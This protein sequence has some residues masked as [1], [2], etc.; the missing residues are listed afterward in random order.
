MLVTGCSAFRSLKPSEP[1]SID[2]AV[3]T[4]SWIFKAQNAN[5]QS[6]LFRQLT[7]PYSVNLSTDAL[8]S[9]LPYFGEAYSGADVMT[10]RSPLDFKS[11]NLAVVKEKDKKGAWIITVKPKDYEAVYAYTFTVYD[12]GRAQLMVTLSNR[13][14]I[15]FNGVVEP[16]S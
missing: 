9:D 7:S 5:P 12:N 13:S 15:S 4:N 10:N 1:G 2:N 6:G 8:N 16:G 11:T 3:R 14:P